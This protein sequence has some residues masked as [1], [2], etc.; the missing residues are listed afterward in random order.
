MEC[1]IRRTPIVVSMDLL[2][3]DAMIKYYGVDSFDEPNNR[4]R[5]L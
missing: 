4:W 5:R 2:E 1:R 3:N